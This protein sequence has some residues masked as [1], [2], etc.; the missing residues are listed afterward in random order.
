[1]LKNY[2]FYGAYSF[3]TSERS[4]LPKANPIGPGDYVS[5]PEKSK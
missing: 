4:K 5:Q 1:M 2:P 3:S